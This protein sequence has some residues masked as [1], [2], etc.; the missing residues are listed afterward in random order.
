MESR[1]AVVLCGQVRNYW[2]TLP[3]TKDNIIDNNN[4]DVFC[5]VDNGQWTPTG[6]ERYDPDVLKSHLTSIL[7]SSLKKLAFE[8][9]IPTFDP[10]CKTLSDNINPQNQ[11]IN[12][13]NIVIQWCEK[14]LAFDMLE[15]YMTENSKTYDV[16]LM[17][18][19]DVYY[20]KIT[21]PICDT[22]EIYLTSRCA[23]TTC[24]WMMDNFYFG[25]FAA[26][27]TM[28]RFVEEY[29]K[30]EY[31]ECSNCKMGDEYKFVM[32][33]QFGLYVLSKPG[34][35]VRYI[36]YDIPSRRG[37]RIPPPHKDSVNLLNISYKLKYVIDQIKI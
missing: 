11:D 35:K 23:T 24:C 32:E 4:A 9:D 15:Q 34:L 2:Y 21:I 26:M 37:E 6:Y 22:N 33:V 29:S 30:L 19:P 18:R 36:S 3:Y 17:L 16:V 12:R 8:S 28:S 27:K 14:K 1:I 25:G 20:E 10:Y 13:F 31:T 5:L 7:G